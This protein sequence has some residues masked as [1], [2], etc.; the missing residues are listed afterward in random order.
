M[1]KALKKLAAV[2]MAFTMLGTGTAFTN[3]I[4]PQ[5]NNSITAY[6]AFCQNCQNHNNGGAYC[7]STYYTDWVTY[8]EWNETHEYKDKETK[9]WK[10]I[11]IHHSEQ[12]RDVITCCGICGKE[13]SRY[14]EYRTTNN[15]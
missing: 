6:A 13:F 12:Y 8:N 11:V 15:F 14:R 10:Y 1:K 7:I 4:T 9:K 5:A 2:A 3:T